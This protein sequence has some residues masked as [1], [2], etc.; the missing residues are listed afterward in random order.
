MA[1][2]PKSCSIFGLKKPQ[3]HIFSL[4]NEKPIRSFKSSTQTASLSVAPVSIS[5]TFTKLKQQGKV[6]F[7]PYVVA[8]DPDLSTTAEALKVLD[9]CGSDVIELGIPFS[10]PIADGPVI[11]AACTRALAN[12]T[13]LDS[14]M[15]MLKKV[16]P[17]IS[18]PITLF[19]YYNVIHKRGI[20]NFMAAL[21]DA[22]VHGL[23][24]P[25]VRLEETAYLRKEAAKNDIEMVQLTTPT[26]STERMKL[27]VEAAEGFVYLVSSVGVTGARASVN[28]RVQS[29]LHEIKEVTSKPV[30]VGFG[31]SKPE[32]VQQIARWGADGVIVGSALVKLLGEANSPVEGLKELEIF[33][34]S[35]KSAL[36]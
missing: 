31:I 27:I 32:H 11:Q 13:S 30:T 7:I 35:L 2:A 8:G 12:G 9:S 21:N 29:L 17:E 5:D 24:V 15:S 20:G 14:I 33:T 1:M 26:T 10:D 4:P 18:C 19:T 3:T 34:K 36:P 28:P 6:A 23:V 22:G 16:L 25:D